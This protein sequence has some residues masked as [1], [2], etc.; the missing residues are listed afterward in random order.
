MRF[1]WVLLVLAVAVSAGPADAEG[2]PRPRPP[3]PAAICGSPALIGTP[4]A[5]IEDSGCA[6][7]AP[8]RLV[9]AAGIA[10]EPPP[11][12]TCRTARAVGD[13]LEHGVA[14]SL[15]AAGGRLEALVIVD[16]YSCRN[17]NRA[18][19]AELSEHAFGRAIDVGGFRLAQGGTVDV[20]D[21][22]SSDAW[23]PALRRLHAAGCG[24][25]GTVL[26]PDAN[27]LHADH[28]HVDMAARRSG[29]YCR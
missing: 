6:V 22:W 23:G 18:A 2:P 19:D 21:G 28:L 13:W 26:G 14:P 1:P 11:T 3:A 9:T 8:V 16:A 29:P 20:L 7:D 17:R 12:V 25:F 4:L 10:L 24:S 5:A 27:P 15:A